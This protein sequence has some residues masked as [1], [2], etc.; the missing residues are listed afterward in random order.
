M[1][2]ESPSNTKQKQIIASDEMSS[3][4]EVGRIDVGKVSVD[5]YTLRRHMC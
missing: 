2:F 1:I 5:L 3:V 4:K